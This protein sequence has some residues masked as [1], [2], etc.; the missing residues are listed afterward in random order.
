MLGDT[1]QLITS[2][3]ALLL[4]AAY[5]FGGLV[6]NL[7]LARY[8]V[9]EYQVLRIKYLVVGLVFMANFVAVLV[10]ASVATL[11]ALSL[12]PSTGLTA[13]LVMSLLAAI[14]LIGL[15]A[16]EKRFRKRNLV[17]NWVIFWVLS[18][19]ALLHPVMVAVRQS[20]VGS[21]T[22][23]EAVQ[24]AGAG[25][26][27][28][29]ALIG[30]VYFY[31]GYIYGNPAALDPVGM[32]IPV[33]VRLAGTKADIELLRNL[34]LPAEPETD[35][36]GGLLLLDETDSH[37]IIATGTTAIEQVFKIDKGLVKGIVYFT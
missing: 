1:L 37:Y 17:L 10:G 7:H 25:L 18:T 3:A 12:S 35:L 6:V 24:I 4:G 28:I 13:Y 8:G 30:Q 31:A 23:Y 16:L 5:V 34:G 14:L 15:W 2:I 11:V 36:T 20:I 21:T 9:I 33:R 27:G 26:A 32:G 22:L 29:L 19:L